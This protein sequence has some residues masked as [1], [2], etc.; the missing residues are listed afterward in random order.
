MVTIGIIIPSWHYFANAFKLQPL[1]ELYFAT[2]IDYHFEGKKAKVKVIDL[3]EFREQEGMLQIDKVKSA[4]PEQ[5]IYLYWINKTADYP[6]IISIVHQ[7]RAAYPKAKHAAGGAHVDIFPE[8][9]AE[10]FDAVVLGP[11][12]RSLIKIVEDIF[13]GSLKKI[14]KP[15]RKDVKYG[16]FPFARRG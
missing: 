2:V 11:G 10:H 12:E 13:G 1:N 9:S 4:I 6:E 14:Y 7:L 3:R 8:E 15:E 16:G 5:S